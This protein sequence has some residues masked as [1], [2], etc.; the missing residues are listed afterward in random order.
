MMVMYREI[1]L[2]D[3]A[4]LKIGDWH[5]CDRKDFEK[6]MHWLPTNII[7]IYIYIPARNEKWRWTRFKGWFIEHIKYNGEKVWTRAVVLA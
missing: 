5:E 3:D 2:T 4:E 1:F 7:S 6:F